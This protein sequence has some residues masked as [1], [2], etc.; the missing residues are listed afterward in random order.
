M[1]QFALCCGVYRQ[2][3][4]PKDHVNQARVFTRRDPSENTSVFFAMS[5]G[6]RETSVSASWDGCWTSRSVAGAEGILGSQHNFQTDT[7]PSQRSVG[8]RGWV[9]RIHLGLVNESPLTSVQCRR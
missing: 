4:K 7:K 2:G 8:G 1:S 5:P 6:R 3:V 9:V